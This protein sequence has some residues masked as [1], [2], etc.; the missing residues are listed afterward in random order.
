MS[1]IVTVNIFVR[2]V[3]LVTS[4]PSVNRFSRQYEILRISQPYRTSE[5]ITGI[6][7]PFYNYVDYIR[8]SQETQKMSA[9]TDY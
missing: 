8:T 5:P 7:L 4:P 3:R 2:C 6:D 1:R 9:S